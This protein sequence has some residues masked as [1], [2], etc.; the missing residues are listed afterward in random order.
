M[1]TQSFQDFDAFANSV[2]GIDSVMMLQNAR[3]RIWSISEVELPELRVQMGRLGSGNIVEG[4]SWAGGYLLYLPL[5]ATCAYS[6]NGTVLKRNSF[7]ILEPGCEFSLSTRFEHDWCTIFVPSHKLARGGDGVEPPSGSE[8]MTCRVT[9]ANRQLA[10]QFL[11]CVR[12]VMRV[13]A[14]CSEFESSPAATCAAAKLLKVA[15]SVLGERQTG[16]PKQQRRPRIRRQEII[17]CCRKLLQERD[18]EHVPVGDLVAAAKVCER[19]LRS[20]FHEYFGV[21]PVQY[22]QLRQLHRVHRALRAAD[23]EASSVTDVLIR[24]GEWEFSRFAS[25]YR[26]LFGELPSETLRGRRAVTISTSACR[27]A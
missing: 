25:R 14:I 27:A 12:Q 16:E 13:A 15:S 24:H 17:R 3:R 4:Q 26:R 22:L 7:M 20:T 18:G 6:A 19:T 21:G 11:A 23:P 1:K 2:R 10:N 5:T 8:K 9:R